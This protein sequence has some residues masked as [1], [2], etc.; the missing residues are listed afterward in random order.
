MAVSGT[1]ATPDF[2]ILLGRPTDQS[3]TANIIPNQSGEAYIEYGTTPG[4]YSA[5]R[6]DNFACVADD[7]VEVVINGLSP[8]TQYYYR[9]QFKTNGSSTWIAG[10]EHSFITQRPAGDAFTFTIISDSHL[11][12][13]GGQT[14]DEKAL[15]EQTLENVKADNPDFHIDLGDTFAMDPSPLGTGMTEAEAKAAYYVQ[16]PYLGTISDSVPIFLAL[17]NHENEEGWNFDDVFTAP[18][19]TLAKV[20]MKYRKLVLSQSDPG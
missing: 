6:I 13:Y 20:G 11:G 5:G 18:D 8:D 1:A 17:G 12:Q 10:A 19:Q 7:P 4:S 3:I 16:R 2:N 9:I 14:A 15:Y